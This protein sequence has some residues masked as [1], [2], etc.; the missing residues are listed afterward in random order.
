MSERAILEYYGAIV[1]LEGIVIVWRHSNIESIVIINKQ[2][3][4][5]EKDNN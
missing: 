5:I 1:T 2:V 3:V 4:G